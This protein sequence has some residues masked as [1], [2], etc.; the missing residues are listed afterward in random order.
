[1]ANELP[2]VASSEPRGKRRVV[3]G[4]AVAL[5]VVAAAVLALLPK[6][7]SG[8]SKTSAAKDKPPV[9]LE[10]VAAEVARP[11][12]ARLPVVVEFSGPLVAPRT[13]VVRA[14]A[15]GTLLALSVHE[16]SRVRAG[17]VI[18]E[19]DLAEMQSKVADR[20]AV[21]ESAQAALVEAERQHAANASLAA[22]NF[23]SP[24]AL[25]TSQARLDAARAQVKSAQAQLATSRVGIREATL[26]VPIAGI[27]GKRHVV[28]GEKVTAEQQIVTVVDLSTLELAGSV[29]THEVSLLRAGHSAAVRVEGQA[30]AVAGRIDRIAPAAEAG[31]RAIGVVV[32][33][34]NKGERFRA[35]QYAQARVEL[36]DE[37]ERMTIPAAAVG[38]ASGQDYVWTLEK[39]ALVRRIVVTG[40]RDAATGRVEVRSGLA[41]DAQVLAVR[42]DNLKEGAPAKVVAERGTGASAPSA[43]APAP[44][45][46]ASAA[47]PSRS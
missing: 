34:E 17:Q 9:P 12:M 46:A 42:F 19:I 2:H 31:T 5:L 37:L 18:G 47:A 41:D 40:R 26:A 45:A 15:A 13:A 36:A 43:P 38:Q 8:F 14:K 29:G 30:T 35:G 23:I 21:L 22:Q 24:T 3:I 28:P 44:A 33:L 1:M 25:Q 4:S 11:A 20:S 16:G 6:I 7:G 27:V 39:G 32:V 10:F